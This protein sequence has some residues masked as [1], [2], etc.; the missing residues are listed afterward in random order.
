MSDLE[1]A[2]ITLEF[3]LNHAEF[4][5]SLKSLKKIKHYISRERFLTRNIDSLNE[6]IKKKIEDIYPSVDLSILEYGEYLGVSSN[7]NNISIY[8]FKKSFEL[9]NHGYNVYI[10]IKIKENETNYKKHPNAMVYIF[11]EDGTNLSS[12]RSIEEYLSQ[13]NLF[14]NYMMYSKNEFTFL[15]ALN[16]D[17]DI[18]PIR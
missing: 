12:N 9:N 15:N 5:V 16:I 13:G 10:G 4:N 8:W 17:N 6:Q 7:Y 2:Q 18:I 1:E 14:L 3:L 11:N